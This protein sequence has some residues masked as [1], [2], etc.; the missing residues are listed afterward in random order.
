MLQ[1]VTLPF[2]LK[3]ALVLFPNVGPPVI[4]GVGRMWGDLHVWFLGG[5]L[6]KRPAL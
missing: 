5:F 3:K 6:A 1:E 4:N 2:I